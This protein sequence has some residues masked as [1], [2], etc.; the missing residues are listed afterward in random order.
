MAYPRVPLRSRG[1]SGCPRRCRLTETLFLFLC[2][3]LGLALGIPESLSASGLAPSQEEIQK[4]RN[5]WNPL[6][7]GPLMVI[8]ADLHPQGQCNLRPFFFSQ[9]SEKRFGNDLSVDR[10]TSSTHSYAISPLVT[11]GCG[12]TDHFEVG[13]AISASSFWARDS[14]RFNAGQGGPVTTNTGIGDLTI[15]FAY[16]PIVQDPGSWRP[17]ITPITQIALPTSRWLTS[18]KAPPGDFLPLGRLPASRF[19]R[20]SITEGLLFRKNIQP[21][22]ISG[23]MYYTYHFTGSEAGQDTHVSDVINTRLAFEYVVD[24]KKGLAYNLEF[25]GLHGV[26]FRLDGREINRGLKHG[27]TSLGVEPAVQFKLTD[28]LAGSAGV[29]FTVAGQNALDGIYP[30]FSLFWFW[31]KS[32]KIIMR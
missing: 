21:F 1:A 24:D 25:V 15:G 19:G 14:T 29:L 26:P 28:R 10:T 22:R 2:G 9:I 5:S 32:G 30:N 11:G 12:V 8:S 27:F 20:P 6:S 3:G 31:S 7:Y 17:S 4:Y 23:G 18:T 13:F 16:R